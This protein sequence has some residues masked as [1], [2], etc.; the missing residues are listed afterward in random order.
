MANIIAH[1]STKN[2]LYR[3]PSA[4][5]QPSF[6]D[7]GAN[8]LTQSLEDRNTG[9]DEFLLQPPTLDSHRDSK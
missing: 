5:E 2:F 9:M 6:A 3:N 1:D 4:N 7:I 8:K